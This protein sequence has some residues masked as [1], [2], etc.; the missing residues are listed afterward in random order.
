MRITI[1]G[2]GC[3]GGLIG[4]ALEASGTPVTFVDRGAHLAAL[5]EDGLRVTRAGGGELHVTP[6]RAVADTASLGAQDVVFLALK[7]HQISAAIDDIA[8]LIGSDTIV[9]T[10]QNG[11]PWWYFQRHGGEHDGRIIEGADPGGRI[12]ARID[13]ARIVGCIAYP[14]VSKVAPGHIL[15]V[16]GHRFPVGALDGSES[17]ETL[18]VSVLLE[19]AGFK[20]P[21]LPDIRAEIWLKAI[22]NMSFNP[23]SALTQATL[24]DICEHPDACALARRMMQEGEAVAA[25]L[26]VSLRVSIDRR[27]E[28]ARRVGKHR[29]SMLQDVE[30]GEPLELEA[31]VTA[32]AELGELTGT[33][34]P[35]THDVIALARLLNHVII[36]ERVA[37]VRKPRNG[38]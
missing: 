34:T 13:P 16:E 11:I 4:G 21:V 9:V 20:S 28:G 36:G 25:A 15:H 2:A 27:I 22:G 10:L 32:V 33:Q 23:I 26:G 12:A 5:R 18:R 19:S 1:M 14:A 29:S 6:L 37:I 8:A 24:V 30:N 7:A 35:A 31:L 3:I 17:A 38:A